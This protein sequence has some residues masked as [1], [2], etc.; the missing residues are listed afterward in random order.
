MT[1]ATIERAQDLLLLGVQA[2]HCGVT[3]IMLI[4]KTVSRPLFLYESA[5][6]RGETMCRVTFRGLESVYRGRLYKLGKRL[7]DP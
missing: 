2:N 3:P 1:T 4:H 6:I 7:S 5:R